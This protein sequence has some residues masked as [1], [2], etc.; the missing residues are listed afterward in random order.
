M[1][2]EL[3]MIREA[4][5]DVVLYHFEEGDRA[6]GSAL[7]LQTGE[8]IDL[9]GFGLE[10]NISY[11][12]AEE[13]ADTIKSDLDRYVMVD[14]YNGVGV[15]GDFV[16]S[17]WTDDEALRAN[18]VDEWQLC[19]G[20]YGPWKAHAPGEAV[21][22]FEEFER[23]RKIEHAREFLARHGFKLPDEQSATA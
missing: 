2:A 10:A 20:R 19:N 9:D 23:Q 14:T 17:N 6:H 7:D 22:A 16:Q 3:R 5:L 4:D 8:L 15:L 12:E 13:R 21:E 18:A 1:N 11:E